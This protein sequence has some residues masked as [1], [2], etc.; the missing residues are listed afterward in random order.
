M[1]TNEGEEEEAK[2]SEDKRGGETK[3]IKDERGRLWK[4]NNKGEG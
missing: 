3:E 4:K 2:W 1:K